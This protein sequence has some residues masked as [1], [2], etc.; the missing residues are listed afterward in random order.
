MAAAAVVVGAGP[1]AAGVGAGSGA[2]FFDQD[3]HDRGWASKVTKRAHPIGRLTVLDVVTAEASLANFLTAL[4]RKKLRV[5]HTDES[6]VSYTF[7]W[8]SGYE[9][10]PAIRVQGVLVGSE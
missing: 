5:Q 7:A 9:N 2:R 1:R 6:G 10:G 4:D 8:A 3:K